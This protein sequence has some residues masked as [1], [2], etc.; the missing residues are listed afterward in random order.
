MHQ[1]I[2]DKAMISEQK[3][4]TCSYDDKTKIT[5]Y[6]EAALSLDL[7]FISNI[8]TFSN[9]QITDD[10][11]CKLLRL[12]SIH[13]SSIFIVHWLVILKKNPA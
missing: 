6:S 4:Y 11:V 10:N 7:Y 9:V 2:T 5:I 13:F 3:W 1:L 12:S 8:I